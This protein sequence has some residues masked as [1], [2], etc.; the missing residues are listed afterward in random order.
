MRSKGRERE[1][2]EGGRKGGRESKRKG[3]VR[4]RYK[5][6]TAVLSLENIVFFCILIKKSTGQCTSCSLP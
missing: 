2:R 3:K 1:G 5:V 4:E 6:C